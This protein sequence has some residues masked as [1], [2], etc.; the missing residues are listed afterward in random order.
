MPLLSI[1]GLQSGPPLTPGGIAN[2][3]PHEAH[4]CFH[5]A[6]NVDAA[7]GGIPFGRGCTVSALPAGQT[8]GA[9][10]RLAVQLAATGGKFAG[11]AMFTDSVVGIL[12]G[13]PEDYLTARG[14]LPNRELALVYKGLVGVEVQAAVTPASP[15]FVVVTAG[16]EHGMFRADANAAGAIAVP[17]ATFRGSASAGGTV[18]LY[19]NLDI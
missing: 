3:L 12:N 7:L 5:A 6:A 16:L 4:T 17:G 10:D 14:Y 11:V 19:L 15:V 2:T 8:Y 18:A 9:Y 1:P 13:K